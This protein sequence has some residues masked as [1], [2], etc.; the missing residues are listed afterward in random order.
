MNAPMR[1]KTRPWMLVGILLLVVAAFYGM[2]YL[3]MGAQGLPLQLDL[4]PAQ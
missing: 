4:S 2:D 3:I 1:R